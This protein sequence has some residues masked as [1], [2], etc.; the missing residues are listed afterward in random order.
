MAQKSCIVKQVNAPN[1]DKKTCLKCGKNAQITLPY[2]PQHYCKTHFIELF[3]KRVRK[4]IR[5]NKLVLPG[6]KIVIGV[7]GGKDSMISLY[8]LKKICPQNEI[9]A[10]MIDEGIHGYR[11]KAIDIAKKQ[12]DSWNISYK[13]VSYEKEFGHSMD[14]IMKH[15]HQNKNLGS[16]C[17]FCGVFRRRLLNKF[18]KNLNA[19]K[20]ATGHNLD[21]EAQSIVMN[22]FDNDVKKFS[23]LGP[24]VGENQKNFIPRIKPLYEIPEKEIVAFASFKNIQHYS[25]E[26]CPYSWQAKRNN[27]RNMLNDFEK[28]YPGTKHSVQKF[29]LSIR[30]KMIPQNLTQKDLMNCIKCGSHSNSEI[31][32]VC[33]KIDLIE[34]K[35]VVKST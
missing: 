29:L 32:P 17:S 6:E 8:L 12:C 28:T 34:S 11:N 24:I 15:L 16:S 21:D 22:V 7:S 5:K 9:I 1:P 4:T 20:L 35:I 25:D 3:E 31:C 10:L 27:Y 14:K 19:D 33:Q 18:A 26:C 30:E 13:I 23:R 2:G